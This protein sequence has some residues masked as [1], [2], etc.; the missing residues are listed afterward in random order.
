MK[1]KQLLTAGLASVATIHA[2]HN[3]Y[4]SMEKRDA[5]RKAVAEGDM[6]LEEARK[7]KAKATLQD[8][9]SIGIA[10]LGIKG[11]FSE[12]KEANQMRL[13]CRNLRQEKEER[14]QRRLQRLQRNGDTTPHGGEG[15]SRRRTEP[16]SSQYDDRSRY[17]DRR[18][19]GPQYT[20]GN[21]Y[22]YSRAGTLPAPPVGYDRR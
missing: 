16:V 14:H 3:V 17:D 22:A 9:A 6:T 7:L 2:A 15:I 10:A 21:P 19:Y 12:I 11:A 5:R 13:D 18:D 1:G 4:Q 8:V 20:D